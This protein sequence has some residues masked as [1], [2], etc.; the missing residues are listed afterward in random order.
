[1]PPLDRNP[2]HPPAATRQATGAAPLPRQVRERPGVLVADDDHLTRILVQLVLARAGFKVW[3]AA[4]GREAIRLYRAHRE[5]IAVVLLDVHMPVLDGPATLDALRGLNPE[6]LACFMSGDTGNYDPQELLRRGATSI[7]AK[8]FQINRLA[9][10]LRLLR[11]GVPA[12]LLPSVGGRL[13]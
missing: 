3:L 6:V 1:M 7:V 13:G 9:D 12:D 10:H 2:I 8:P 5:G 4:N 11:Q